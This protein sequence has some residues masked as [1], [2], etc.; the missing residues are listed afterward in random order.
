MGK[1]AR[2]Q[3]RKEAAVRSSY[4]DSV[5]SRP[6]RSLDE[7]DWAAVA[8][9]VKRLQVVLLELV[10]VKLQAG[11]SWGVVAA[12]VGVSRSTAQSKYRALRTATAPV[13]CAAA[14]PPTAGAGRS[15]V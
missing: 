5:V 8:G 10:R 11:A 13:S 15:C 14:R 9:E 1:A 3:R 7:A 2:N 4:S 12:A 6:V